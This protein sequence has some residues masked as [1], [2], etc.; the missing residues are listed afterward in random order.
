MKNNPSLSI[1]G[2]FFGCFNKG[3]YLLWFFLFYFL[4]CF[5]LFCFVLVHYHHSYFSRL[6]QYKIQNT[7]ASLSLLSSFLGHHQLPG[8]SF[9]FFF[10]LFFLFFSL[11][12]FRLI[13]GGGRRGEGGYTYTYTYTYTFIPLYLYTF[14]INRIRIRIVVLVSCYI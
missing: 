8:Y 13:K 11:P 7:N 1:Q 9:S 4:F 12:S 14:A 3:V 10:F 6:V 2:L 5:V